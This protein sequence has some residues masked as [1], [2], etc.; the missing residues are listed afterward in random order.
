MRCKIRQD[1][2]PGESIRRIACEQIEAAIA[3]SRA[4]SNGKGSPVHQTRKHL[5]KARAALRLLATEV[6]RERFRQEDRRL[7]NVGRLISNIRDAE[8]RLATVKQLRQG[9]DAPRSRNFTETEE[10]LAFELDSFLAAFSG[11]QEEAAS[12]L[13]R[14]QAGIADWHLHRLS[15]NQI[16]RTVRKSYRKGRVAL[17]CAR[18]KGSAKKFHELRKRAK[19]LWYQLRLLR[20]LKPKVFRELSNR[21]KT[22]G[23]NLGHAH[24]LCFVA[25]RL[26]SIAGAGT[27]KRGS[28][29]LEALIDS[30]EKDLLR[31]ACALGERFYA[32]KPKEFSGR[33]AGYFAERGAVKAGRSRSLAHQSSYPLGNF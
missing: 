19:E 26:Q 24:D 5:K 14:A 32:T 18:K 9:P 30:R 20:P 8:V 31:A 28:R 6:S 2:A 3:A 25:E 1:E 4:A 17:E 22:L 21:L 33:I 15:R 7:R 27:N 12:K 13:Q 11:W 16:C 29:A 23:E 10:L